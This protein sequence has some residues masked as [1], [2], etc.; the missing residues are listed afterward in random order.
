MKYF[1]TLWLIVF[2]ALCLIADYPSPPAGYAYE[3]DL[4]SHSLVLTNAAAAGLANRSDIASATNALKSDMASA[5]KPTAI[6]TPDGNTWT[7]AT[8]C[9]WRV[10][11]EDWWIAEY[12]YADNVNLY[13]APNGDNVWTGS[14]NMYFRWRAGKWEVGFIEYYD[15]PFYGSQ[16]YVYWSTN[17][18]SDA[19]YLYE[20]YGP[21]WPSF[22]FRKIQM[23]TTNLVTRFAT[24]SAITNT[25]RAVQGLVYDE[26]LGIT[27]RQIMY[28]G[29]LYYVA[30]TN[31]NITEVQ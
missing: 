30:V 19:T 26:K 20:E 16:D 1:L 5:L 2:S 18:P 14:G 25:V 23:P 9:V 3:T 17:A 27:W 21:G 31:A 22:V 13:F 24:E 10:D 28:D 7:D 4:R 6:F 11:R 12:M 15:Y 8:G 29:N